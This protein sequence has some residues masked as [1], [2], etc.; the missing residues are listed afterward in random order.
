M[1]Y[2]KSRYY[3]PLLCRFISPDSIDYLDPNSINGLNLYAYCGNNPI[4][5]A[6]S[7]GHMPEWVKTG[8]VVLAGAIIIAAVV[9]L[10]V[11]SGGT[12]APVLIGAAL[13]ATAGGVSSAAMQMLEN[14]KID[15]AQLIIDIT[16]GGVMGAFGGSTIGRIGM[17][18]AGGGTG[19]ASSIADNWVHGE[20]CANNVIQYL[21][22]AYL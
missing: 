12:A 4:I 10:T 15:V 7:S 5:Y 6:D 19:F 21:I 22:T 1:Y 2:C 11:A 17:T 16:V 14:G 13:G 20:D 9:A 8:L 18:L 3:S